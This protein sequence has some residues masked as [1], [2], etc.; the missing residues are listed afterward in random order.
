M[1]LDFQSVG[2]TSLEPSMM[3]FDRSLS[4]RLEFRAWEGS[5]FLSSHNSTKSTIQKLIPY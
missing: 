5:A 4:A 2:Q 3:H 1:M